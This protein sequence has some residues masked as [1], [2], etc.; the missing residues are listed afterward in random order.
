M[1]ITHYEK[2][3]DK[4]AGIV[5]ERNR[6]LYEYRTGFTDNKLHTFEEIGKKF[7]VT[8]GRARQIFAKVTHQIGLLQDELQS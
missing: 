2:I 1:L 4:L 7:N 6:K 5:S 3:K 8:P